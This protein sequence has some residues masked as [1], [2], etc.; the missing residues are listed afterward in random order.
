[1]FLRMNSLIVVIRSRF[2]QASKNPLWS[3]VA[4]LG[5]PGDPGKYDL[6]QKPDRVCQPVLP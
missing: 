6:W 2:L 4:S 5:E 3:R 1:M